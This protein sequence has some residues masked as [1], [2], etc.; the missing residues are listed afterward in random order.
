MEKLFK[1]IYGNKKVL[2][3][4][5]SGFKGSWLLLWLQQLGATVKGY[6]LLPATEPAHLQLLGLL[7]PSSVGDINHVGQLNKAFADFQPDIVFHLAAQP[8]V[9]RSY[10]DPLE[11]FG[12][13]ILG[14]ANVLNAVTQTPSVKAVVN[15]TTDKVY[16]N[17]E[18]TW[19]YRETDALGGHDPYST[20]KACVELVHESFRRSFFSDAGILS[21]TAR[22]GN[23][24]G[25]GDWAE[26]RLVPDVIRATVRSGAADIRSP[27]SIRPW[28]HVLD[29]LSGYLLLG[30][31]LLQ[32]E[33]AAEGAWNFG[34]D[35]KDCLS[36]ADV[37]NEL[38]K[39]WAGI[40]WKDVSENKKPHESH[41]LRL[42]CSKALHELS[43]SPV[44]NV[45]QAIAATA[46]WY[47]RFYDHRQVS[48][49][50]DLQQYV[51][52]AKAKQQSWAI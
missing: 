49:L 21:V 30:Q 24:I 41:L 45:Q 29:P 4:G 3:T 16:Q 40:Q 22:A 12:T 15:I 36:V 48:S 31:L 14:T 38:S 26:D 37:L 7:D 1:G 44:W 9:R 27:Q 47:R 25:G 33:K 8:L 20:S 17:H 5:H 10:T 18:W 19:P 46:S 2:L 52:D 39:N 34:P 28:Q 51:Q 43:W 32:G 6:S 23:V 13:N 35:I 11:T 42:D 50:Q